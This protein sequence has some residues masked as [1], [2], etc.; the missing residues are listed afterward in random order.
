MTQFSQKKILS[1]QTL[2]D[3]LK[4]ARRESGLSLQEIGARL[5]INYQYLNCLENGQYNNL[6]SE[7]YIKNYLK[8]YSTFL[9]VSWKVV[10]KMYEQEMIIYKSKQNKIISSKFS[11]KALV[12]PS[13]VYALLIGFV[14][15]VVVLYLMFEISNFIQPPFLEVRNV[16]DQMIVRERNIQI[17]GK[18]D[19]DAQVYIN[20][21]EIIT[22]ENGNWQEDISLQIGLNTIMIT[23]KKKHSKENIIY[24]RIFVEI[25]N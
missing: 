22:D 10:E 5:K 8:K 23:A 25:N 15:L 17:A 18:A 1:S 9:Q 7:V 6:P 13:I 12:I 14:F 24:K 4:R 11:Q 19:V 16:S 21:E 2:G 3:K 20:G